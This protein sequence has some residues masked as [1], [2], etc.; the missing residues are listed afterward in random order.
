M[1]VE[2]V[3]EVLVEGAQEGVRGGACGRRSGS[4]LG[5]TSGLA[6]MLSCYLLRTLLMR[7]DTCRDHDE[8][9]N[10]TTTDAPSASFL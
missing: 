10:L 4:L 3:R 2:G 7:W 1:L 6:G 9:Q 8:N 5:L